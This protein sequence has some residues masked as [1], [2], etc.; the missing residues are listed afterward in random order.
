MP[1]CKGFS[2][3]VYN[4][5][6]NFPAAYKTKKPSETSAMREVQVKLFEPYLFVR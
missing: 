3:G 1:K 6:T 2:G 5:V 4:A